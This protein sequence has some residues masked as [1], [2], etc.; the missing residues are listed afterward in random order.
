MEELKYCQAEDQN[1][2]RTRTKGGEPRKLYM[3]TINL[4]AE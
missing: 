2:I 4:K 1:A 3:S